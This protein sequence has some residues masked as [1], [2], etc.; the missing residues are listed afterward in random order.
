LYE[1]AP[2]TFAASPTWTASNYVKYAKAAEK[3]LDR[4]D[5]GY[6]PTWTAST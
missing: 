2:T 4:T 6:T 3:G 1:I 5:Q